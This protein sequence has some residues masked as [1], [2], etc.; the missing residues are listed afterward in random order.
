MINC[1]STTIKDDED[2][3]YIDSYLGSPPARASTYTSSTSTSIPIYEETLYSPTTGYSSSSRPASAK[4]YSSSSASKTGAGY[5]ASSSRASTHSNIASNGKTYSDSSYLRS[6][7]DKYV[8]GTSYVNLKSPGSSTDTGKSYG[9][10][11]LSS[12]YEAYKSKVNSGSGA[13]IRHDVIGTS[14]VSTASPGSSAGTKYSSRA[15]YVPESHGVSGGRYSSSRG[16][17]GLYGGAAYS[18]SY[19]DDYDMPSNPYS[20]HATYS[21]TLNTGA[22]GSNSPY[23]PRYKTTLRFATSAV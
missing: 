7:P 9:V 8:V 18:A 2:L 20:P 10:G 17:P 1:Y 3:D 15:S 21:T 16:A 22:H 4:N 12:A 5:A 23:G 14:Y 19:L 13:D 11:G 6:P